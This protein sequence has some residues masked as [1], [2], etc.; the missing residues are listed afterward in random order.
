MAT[1][2]RYCPLPFCHWHHGKCG[3]AVNDAILYH[4]GMSEGLRT[5]TEEQYETRGLCPT[6]WLLYAGVRPT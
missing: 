6:A 1:A 2:R 4:G 3:D 5:A